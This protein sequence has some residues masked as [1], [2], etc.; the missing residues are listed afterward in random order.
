MYEHTCTEKGLP[1][2]AR[3]T[4][5]GVEILGTTSAPLLWLNTSGT[6]APPRRLP[7]EHQLREILLA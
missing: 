7:L 5:F 3:R 4:T 6:I 1:A 2:S